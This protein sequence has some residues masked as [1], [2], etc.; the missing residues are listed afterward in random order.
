ME[1]LPRTHKKETN[2]INAWGTEKNIS[3]TNT[4]REMQIKNKPEVIK[5]SLSNL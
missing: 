2:S 5:F 4:N 3:Q 1:N